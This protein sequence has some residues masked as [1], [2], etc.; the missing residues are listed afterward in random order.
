MKLGNLFAT[1]RGNDVPKTTSV[2]YCGASIFRDACYQLVASFLI[3]YITFAGVLDKDPTTYLAQMLVINIFIIVCR[4]WDGINDPIMGWLISKVRFKWGKYKPWI[5]MG[6]LLNTGV[7]LTLFLARPS[8]WGFVILFCIFYFLWDIVY[9]INDIAYWSMLPSLTSD[10]KKRNKITSAMQ[11]CVSIGVFA[12]YGAVPM[13]VVP[14]Q[15]ALSYSII[16]I[17]VTTL[18]L[19]SQIVLVFLCKERDRNEIDALSKDEKVSAKDMLKVFKNNDQFRISIIAILINYLGAGVLVGFAMYYFYL[20]YGYGPDKGGNIQFM[21]TVMYA[22]G[23]LVAQLLYP[24]LIKKMNRRQILIMAASIFTI[25][26]MALFFLGFPLFKTSPLAS[27]ALIILLYISA[28]LIFFGQGLVAIIIII[29]MQSTI[30]YNE[31][32]FGNRQEPIVSSMRALAAKF[33]SAIQQGLIYATLALTGLYGVTQVISNCENQVNSGIMTKPELEATVALELA[34]IQQWQLVG[35]S[36]GM[37]VVPLLL[38]LTSVFLSSFVFKIDE[39][40]Y[41]KMTKEIDER[42]AKIINN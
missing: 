18:F 8:G 33:G 42:K 4:V 5:M 32:K 22:V 14:G 16:A 9:T 23:T 21:F 12:V 2:V 37:V 36:I 41:A 39:K 28:V 15:A 7:V 30:E 40:M 20:M 19:I 35:L 34:N 31:W 11:V 3:T 10:E 6:A 29:Q 25:G 27:G 17:V 38:M 13:L 24:L 1:Y 26:Y